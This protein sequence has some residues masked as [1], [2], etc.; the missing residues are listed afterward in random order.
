MK[1]KKLAI[2]AVIAVLGT[3]LTLSA[4]PVVAG[5][6]LVVDDDGL[7]IPTDCDDTSAADAS[8]VN[9]A[10]TAAS[11]GDTIIVCPGTY[12]EQ[13]VI[14]TD[15]TLLGL[16][17]ATIEATSGAV[18]AMVDVSGATVNIAGFTINGNEG[19]GRS[20]PCKAGLDRFS[21]IRYRDQANGAITH[22]TI[23]DIHLP[24]G[25]L[26]CQEGVGI[27]IRD[28]DASDGTTTVAVT[29][30]KVVDYQKG[31]IVA[32]GEAVS[33]HV[34]GNTVV[35]FGPTNVIAQ[36]G[37][38]LGFKAEGTVDHNY[39]QG[40]F[41]TPP[42]FASAGILVFGFRQGSNVKIANTNVFVGNQVNVLR[43]P[44]C[45]QCLQ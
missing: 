8:T 12:I 18:G 41:F 35:G 14:A 15:L 13:V 9:G 11:S 2:L 34:A 28:L 43:G 40:N 27:E 38:Q 30:N 3:V 36:N 25:F 1:I 20:D 6:T 31:G 19:A 16:H 45:G 37:I 5:T 4:G 39:I 7:A 33:A 23:V 42:T 22:N 44:V 21:G 29:G 10:V 17:G 24:S 32:N 26:G